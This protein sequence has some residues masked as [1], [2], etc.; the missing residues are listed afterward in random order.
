MIDAIYTANMRERV[1]GSFHEVAK[2]VLV[3]LSR[4]LAWLL[5]LLLGLLLLF[6]ALLLLLAQIGVRTSLGSFRL[7]LVGL[8]GLWLNLS[9]FSFLELAGRPDFFLDI[10]VGRLDCLLPIVC[11]LLLYFP[12]LVLPGRPEFFVTGNVALAFFAVH[13]LGLLHP[14]LLLVAVCLIGATFQFN[15]DLLNHL[16]LFCRLGVLLDVGNF[17]L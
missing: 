5:G 1:G 7:R 12:V 4:S 13:A 2:G 6:L 16:L 9:G 11:S 3:A 8:F 10:F 15:L 14:F 17:L